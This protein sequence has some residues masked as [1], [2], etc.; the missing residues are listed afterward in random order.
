MVE[1]ASR[2]NLECRTALG[3]SIVHANTVHPS[4]VVACQLTPNGVLLKYG[5]SCSLTDM[6]PGP[7]I[8]QKQSGPKQ[9]DHPRLTLKTIA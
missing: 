2:F 4:L 7:D 8:L 9:S 6:Q 3:C 1:S 5:P